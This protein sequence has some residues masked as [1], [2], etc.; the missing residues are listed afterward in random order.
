MKFSILLSDILKP[1]QE[2]AGIAGVSSNKDDITQNVLVK[3][4]QGRLQLKATDYNLELEAVL[5]LADLQEEGTITVNAVK[6]CETLKHLD[7]NSL[8]SFTSDASREILELKASKTNFEIRTRDAANFPPFEKETEETVIVLKQKQLKE[9]IDK[10]KFCIAV[11]DFREYLR[12]M[13]LE[14]VDTTLS[15]F[16]SDGHR[17]A[18]LDTQLQAPVKSQFGAIL[19][20]KCADELSKILDPNADTNIELKFTKKTVSTELNG[21]V[22]SSKLL[23]CSYPNVRSV[24][25]KNIETMIS[26][27]TEPLAKSINRVSVMAS[28]RVNGVSFIFADN[29][30]MLRSENS[31]HEIA[32]D[33]LSIDYNGT[34]LE[35]ALNASY[36]NEAL[37]ATKAQNVFFCFTSPIAHALV[38]PESTDGENDVKSM[39]II[40]KVIV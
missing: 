14:A 5:P 35:I 33:E 21:F 24:I 29:K 12:G 1:L 16:T 37:N 27:P 31:E 32:T 38:K 39:Y 7:A 2:V 11:E 18:I 23:V 34:P 40:S 8:V 15:V 25:P 22:L 17:M 10:S 3:A 28:K 19:T 26:I 30:V 36:V 6:L 20:K 4:E 13:R 9:L